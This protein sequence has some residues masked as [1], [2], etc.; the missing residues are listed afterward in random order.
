MKS[1]PKIPKI[2]FFVKQ[3]EVTTENKLAALALGVPVVFRNADAV[4]D[5]S[6][7]FDGVIGDIP[8]AYSQHPLANVVLTQYKE[9][10]TEATQSLSELVDM[11]PTKQQQAV[12]AAN[13]AKAAAEA[14][15]AKASEVKPNENAAGS[16]KAN[17]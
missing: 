10:L 5:D 17:N 6:E 4:V 14:E 7:K 13:A 1:L 9:L 8:A 11:A 2:C 3:G 15:K 16:W 12:D